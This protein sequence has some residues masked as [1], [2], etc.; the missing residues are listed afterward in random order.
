[1]GLNPNLRI[2]YITNIET[3]NQLPVAILKSFILP[4]ACIGIFTIKLARLNMVPTKIIRR[5]EDV[6]SG[7]SPRSRV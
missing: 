1:M 7:Y 3:I 6:K 5:K 2:K 4:L